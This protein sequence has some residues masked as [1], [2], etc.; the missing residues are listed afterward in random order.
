MVP[1]AR[2][3]Y[4]RLNG[5]IP[6]GLEFNHLCRNRLCVNPK[7]L[8]PVTSVENTRR[9]IT[10]NLTVE[11]VNEI[12]SRYRGWSGAAVG[13][14]FGVRANILAAFDEGSHGVMCR[15]ATKIELSRCTL[16]VKKRRF[17]CALRGRAVVLR[18]H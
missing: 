10:T 17:D 1:A 6:A 11:N 15:V 13:R 2:Y 14:L 18:F 5:T 4:E 8:E 16:L 3:F 7:H 12:V 9:T